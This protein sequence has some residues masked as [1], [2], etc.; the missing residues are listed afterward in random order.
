MT[1]PTWRLP[2]HMD[3]WTRNERLY[4]TLKGMG[5]YVVPIPLEGDPSRIDHFH[6]STGLPAS[7]AQQTAETDIHAP[8]ERAKVRDV[9]RPSPRDGADVVDFPSVL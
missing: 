6:V 8:M 1:E 2:E 9:V 4:E 3:Q 5:L 7:L